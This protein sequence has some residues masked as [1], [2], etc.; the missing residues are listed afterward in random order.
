MLNENVGV[1]HQSNGRK[2]IETELDRVGHAAYGPYIDTTPG[3][4]VVEFQIS[5]SFDRDLKDS[6]HVATIDV[7]SNYGTQILAKKK[8]T[9][10]DFRKGTTRFQ[11][12]FSVRDRSS[13]EYRVA[14][15]GKARLSIVV[16][17]SQRGDVQTPV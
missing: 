15:F 5:P 3:D 4:Y 11:L 7:C 14:T 2:Y 13:L 12:P 8:L 1:I 10:K 16:L 9:A 6:D 17:R